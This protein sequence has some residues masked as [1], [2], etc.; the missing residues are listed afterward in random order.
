[1]KRNLLLAALLTA[2]LL[3]VTH[4]QTKS[5]SLQP[6]VGDGKL[7]HYQ[8][9]WHDEFD[10]D[11]VNTVEWNYRKGERFW[12]TQRPENVSVADGKLRLTLKKEKFGASEYT[13]GGLISK[14]EFKFGYYETRLKMPRGKGW[15]TSF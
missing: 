7:N 1:M 15:H 14:R 12:S 6:T 10:G 4:S 9:I 13:A 8:L 3:P 2:S 11:A 5:P